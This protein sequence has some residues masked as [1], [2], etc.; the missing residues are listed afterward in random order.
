[1]IYFSMVKLDVFW[2]DFIMVKFNIF[3]NDLCIVK[4]YV[5]LHFL[6]GNWSCLTR[7]EKTC[8]IAAYG[9]LPS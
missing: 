2:H 7:L 6:P 4:Y 1:M 8:V 3:L 9:G 5:A